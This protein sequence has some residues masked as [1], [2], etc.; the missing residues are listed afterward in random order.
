M[1][2]RNSW[3]NNGWEFPKFIDVNQNTNSGSSEYT[4]Q[5]K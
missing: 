3:D 1:N 2:W 4:K 5:D